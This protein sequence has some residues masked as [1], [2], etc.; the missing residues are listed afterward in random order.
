MRFHYNK[1]LSVLSAFTGAGAP[2]KIICNN[3][4]VFVY[5]YGDIQALPNGKVSF[6]NSAAAVFKF[7]TPN[8]K[9]SRVSF[10]KLT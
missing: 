2:Q 6:Q 3:Q 10:I 9:V 8:K 7:K 1:K 5:F 4:K